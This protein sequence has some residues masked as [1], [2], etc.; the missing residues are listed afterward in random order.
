[1]DDITDTLAPN[2][3]QLDAVDLLGGPRIFTVERVVV[4][5]GAEQP[6]TV[7]L[8]EFDRPW[9]PGKNM[10]RVLGSCWSTKSSTWPGQRVELFCDPDVAYGG[11]SVGGIR[12]SRLSG[13]DE[14]KKV[15]QILTRGKS[16]T[17][18]VE[19]L[20]GP[21]A[22]ERVATLRNEWTSA[23]PERRKAIEAE[24]DSLPEGSDAK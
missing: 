11:K 18:L 7:H 17:Y 2:S 21:T 12:I 1:M 22:A 24:V 8:A 9:K 23:D 6:V 20:A 13:I 3:T 19:P 14:P 16:S 10:R 4:N 5:K 15:P